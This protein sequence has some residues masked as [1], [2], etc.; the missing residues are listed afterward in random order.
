MYSA[1]EC[2]MCRERTRTS[3]GRARFVKR[4]HFQSSRHESLYRTPRRRARIM[5]ML[6]LSCAS[7]SC[8]RASCSIELFSSS[9]SYAGRRRGDARSTAASPP[10]RATVNTVVVIFT[11]NT[12]VVIF[13][14]NTV[15]VIF[16]VSTV[17]VRKA[18]RSYS[19]RLRAAIG[20][21][22]Q[23][24]RSPAVGR[25]SPAA[26]RRWICRRRRP[27]RLRH[28][29]C[30]RPR[31]VVPRAGR[32]RDL[33]KSNRPPRHRRRRRVSSALETTSRRVDRGFREHFTTRPRRRRK[34]MRRRRARGE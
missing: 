15:I 3:A 26:G 30:A 9:L 6:V 25:R 14:V 10:G 12:V 18:V 16:A 22:P 17:I 27:R 4:M 31:R 24:R 21:P 23:A 28:R 5:E 32:R 34:R 19:A 11:V 1:H 8:C 13:A 29:A 7:C 2:I 33:G 20:S